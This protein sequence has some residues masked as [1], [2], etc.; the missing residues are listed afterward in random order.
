[1]TNIGENKHQL[2]IDIRQFYGLSSSINDVTELAFVFRNVDGSKEGKTAT[3]GDIFVAV[4]E[5]TSFE[6]FFQSPTEQQLVVDENNSIDISIVASAPARIVVYDNNVLI[7]EEIGVTKLET[8]YQPTT[9]GNHVVRFEASTAN[10]SKTAAFTYIYD[11]EFRV[12][13]LQPSIEYG[14]NYDANAARAIIAIHAPF[15]K[16]VFLLSNINEF[17]LQNEYLLNRSTDGNDWWIEIP[18]KQDEEL[19]YQYL[20]DGELKIADPLSTLI[21]DPMHDQGVP[22]NQSLP[23]YPSECTDGH[24]SYFLYDPEIVEEDA[25]QSPAKKDLVIYELLLRDFLE[26][27]SFEDLIDTL[28]YLKRLGVNAIELMPIQEFEVND[29]WGY[30][31]SYHMAIDKY[32]GSPSDFRRLVGEAHKNGIAVILDV[33]FNHAFGESPLV[34]LYWDQQLSRPS[35][36]SPYFNPVAK[37]PFNVGFDFNHESKATQAYVNQILKY[38][39]EEFNIDGYRFD[40]SKGF[41]QRMSA[42]NEEM[43]TYDGS[44]IA[45]L[46]GYANYVWSIDTDQYVIL[47]HFAS[48]DEELELANA[49]MM[50]WGNGNYNF[51]EATMGYHEDGKSDFSWQSYK[52]RGWQS[53]NVVGYMESH[54]EERLMYKNLQFGNSNGSYN[55]KSVDVALKRNA[56]AAVF[57]F[58][59][60]G[61]KML[62]QFGELGYDFSINRCTNGVVED[63][64]LDRKPIRWD[65]QN[66]TL[67][68]GLW[69]VYQK[70]IELKTQNPLFKT[71]DFKTEF[72]DPVKVIYLNSSEGNGVVIGNFDVVDHNLNIDFV[73]SGVWH[74]VFSSDSINV[75]NG[76]NDFELTPGEYHLFLDEKYV[77]TSIADL[78]GL[79]ATIIL[80]PNPAQERIHIKIKGLDTTSVYVEIIDQ[81]GRAIQKNLIG[82]TEQ[83]SVDIQDLM[84]GHYFVK[85]TT[86]EG[87]SILP[88]IKT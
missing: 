65:Y 61:P 48:N 36:K 87:R 16:H 63:C 52:D 25:F 14:L 50:L 17:Q 51:N 53:P 57:F 30:N 73:K 37:H 2:L 64:R 33:V 69:K 28:S 35:T 38:W 60:P 70:M 45:I 23:A 41:T 13:D 43:S 76:T 59:I 78:R 19:F 11:P 42:N 84:P 67:R 83:Y 66:E 15:K 44:R 82:A 18:L 77:S 3:G 12:A 22:N 31:P 80:F 71:S 86:P 88:F 40:L 74:D 8:V 21:L 4:P 32:Y 10:F 62:W 39:I 24:L 85:I 58:S 49:G 34:Q 26:S 54:D 68:Q 56:M 55:V 79:G 27:H 81:V 75:V 47:E 72:G 7:V 9:I 46:K 20:V 29:S 5:L 6:V 1:M